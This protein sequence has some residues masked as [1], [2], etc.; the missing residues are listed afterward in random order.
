MSNFS[1]QVKQK[2]AQTR[3]RLGVLKTPH[4]KIET[5][6]FL[7]V[8]TLATVKTMTPE[9]LVAVG[10]QVILA[11]A[12]HLY[13]RPGDQVVKKLG[14]LHQLMHWEH[15]ILTD[16]GGFQ[17]FSLAKLNQVTDRGVYFQS[18]ID[19]SKHFLSPKKAITIQKNLGAD[20]IM[21]FD[22]CAP[23]PCSH[24][25]AREAMERTHLWA[26]Q[27]KKA[28]Q[29]NRKQMLFGIIQGS[30]YPDLRKASAQFIVDLD[31][32]GIAIGGVSVGESR[33]EMYTV[34]KIVTPF[35]P[36]SKPRHLLGVGSPVDLLESVAQGMDLF[37]CVLPTRIARNG[38]FYTQKGRYNLK[39]ARFTTDRGPLEPKCSCYTC[40]NY[41]RGYLRH[42]VNANEILGIHL[43]TLHNLAFILNLM[44]EIRNSISKGRFKQFRQKFIREFGKHSV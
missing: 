37:D 32:P 28:W 12:Y 33:R 44:Q 5:P 19:G 13:L 22:Q 34:L 2:C 8:G 7:P 24:S 15:P 9:E 11:N 4:G 41:S 23:Y 30:V 17:V 20:L 35:L 38:A 6:A 31:L 16:S 27:G 43:L 39:N 29:G 3:A 36:D 10:A 21:S 40:Q 18:H 42:L 1:F 14:G 26:K 25:K